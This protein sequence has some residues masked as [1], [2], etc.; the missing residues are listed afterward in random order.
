MNVRGRWLEEIKK[1]RGEQLE[2]EIIL[3][4][5]RYRNV[6]YTA[7]IERIQIS[8]GALCVPRHKLIFEKS[9]PVSAK[10]LIIERLAPKACESFKSPRFGI[11]AAG[12]SR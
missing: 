1:V 10:P 3:L 7:R 2:Q 9:L 4:L 8:C 5:Y 6:R 12:I 11:A